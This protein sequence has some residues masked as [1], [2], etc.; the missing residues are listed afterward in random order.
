LQQSLRYRGTELRVT[1]MVEG[2]PWLKLLHISAVIVWCGSLLYLP[3]LVRSTAAPVSES[4]LGLGH[5]LPRQWPRNVF[6]GVCTPAAL[7]AIGSGTVLFL[8]HGLIAPWLMFKL[9][10]VGLLVLGHGICGLLVLR[11][12][13]GRVGACRICPALTA[14]MLIVLL[15]IAWLVLGKAV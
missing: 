14:A 13:A 11:A 12:E 2:V 1:G 7:V 15:V 9:L 3:M 5:S 6:I 4:A 8:L 10:G